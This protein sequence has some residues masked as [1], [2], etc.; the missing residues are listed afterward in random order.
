MKM[1]YKKKWQIPQAVIDGQTLA[2]DIVS[3]AIGSSKGV[4]EA[5]TNALTLAGGKIELLSQKSADV[6]KEDK[7]YTMVV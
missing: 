6:Q 3:G 1:Y 4:L 2:V 5:I 7:E